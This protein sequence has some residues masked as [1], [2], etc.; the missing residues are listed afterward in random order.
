M[1]RINIHMMI[2]GSSLPAIIQSPYLFEHLLFIAQF[3]E[4]ISFYDI[5]SKNR[6]YVQAFQK[7]YA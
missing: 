2:K 6:K 7:K 4:G 1:S 3:C 5:H